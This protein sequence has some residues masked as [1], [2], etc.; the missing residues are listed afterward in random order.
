VSADSAESGSCC[1]GD[2]GAPWKINLSYFF[3]SLSSGWMPW[4]LPCAGWPAYPPNQFLFYDPLGPYS[5]A[6]SYAAL[7]YIFSNQLDRVA[8]HLARMGAIVSLA[9]AAGIGFCSG[10]SPAGIPGAVRI[11]PRHLEQYRDVEIS[12]DRKVV[13]YCAS[14]GEF[15]SARVALVLKQKGIDHVRP[16]AGGLQA[17][18]DRG[19]P[20]TS[21][22]R[23]LQG[24][25]VHGRAPIDG[26]KGA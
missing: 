21:D 15:T 18:H 9:A 22:V 3:P 12:P 4:P 1:S 24:P 17:W 19:F 14:P 6:F 26:S 16:L 2:A 23:I 13:L 10:S 25:V 8:V 7:G 20:V 5:G 11:G